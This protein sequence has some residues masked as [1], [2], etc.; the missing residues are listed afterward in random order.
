MGSSQ[1]TGREFGTLDLAEFVLAHADFHTPA[2]VR[3]IAPANAVCV[4]ETEQQVFL[5]DY[6]EAHSRFV[7]TLGRLETEGPHK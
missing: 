7:A 4:E 6:K 5:R 2:R 3:M 1:T